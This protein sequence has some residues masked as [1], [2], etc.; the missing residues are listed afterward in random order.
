MEH[1]KSEVHI[2]AGD[3]M[4]ARRQSVSFWIRSRAQA[5]SDRAAAVLS[6]IAV[7]SGTITLTTGGF[8]ETM[9]ML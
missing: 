4:S 6:F 2:R 5:L 8:P 7:A 1:M 9:Y 3:C